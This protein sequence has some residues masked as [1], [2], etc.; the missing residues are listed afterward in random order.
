MD[1]F[2][3][4]IYRFRSEI[5]SMFIINGT[6]QQFFAG[7]GLYFLILYIRVK[8]RI[9][10]FIFRNKNKNKRFFERKVNGS[11]M[12]LDSTD[13]GISRE[14]LYV[15]RREHFSTEFIQ[16]FLEPGDVCID[17]GSNIGYYALL[18]S[19][20]I[21]NSGKIFAIEPSHQNIK[22]LNKNIKIN[23]YN[24]IVSFQKA[25]GSKNHSGFLGLSES[26]NQ[27]SFVNKNLGPSI[28]TEEVQIVSLDTFLAG[29]PY[30]QFIRMDLEGYEGE[31]IKG[32]KGI[33]R[34]NKPLKIFIEFHTPLLKD[35]GKELLSTL[36]DAGFII[37][38][39]F[40]ERLGIVM[41]E[42]S[43]I[44]SLY[45]FLFRKRFGLFNNSL[46]SYNVSIDE[47]IRHLPNEL[48]ENV[49]ELFFERT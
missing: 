31:I 10:F 1:I 48:K 39:V 6:M 44:I 25:V 29:K 17:I 22:L 35:N 43:P 24:N 33:F 7:M 47:F 4:I 42:S 36:H 8:Y 46:A 45:D 18:E 11:S 12:V 3:K 13:R 34:E 2:K 27:H 20:F 37:K 16:K 14:L 38:A 5:S 21:G 32:M 19:R 9:W 41:K 49:F 15:G 28:L 40:K 23:N 26:A 30:P